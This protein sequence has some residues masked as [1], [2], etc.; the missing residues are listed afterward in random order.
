MLDLRSLMQQALGVQQARTQA[1]DVQEALDLSP[2]LPVAQTGNRALGAGAVGATQ[3]A[4]GS[5]N[6]SKLAAGVAKIQRG[7]YAGTGASQDVAVAFRPQL[8]LCIAADISRWAIIFAGVDDQDSGVGG[9]GPVYRASTTTADFT[10]NGFTLAAA[11]TLNGA[12]Q[13]FFWVAIGG[14]T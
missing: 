13:T 14:A 7:T 12:G 8:L 10:A 11:S 5:V 4:A 1:D 3:L 9:S 6:Q 2:V